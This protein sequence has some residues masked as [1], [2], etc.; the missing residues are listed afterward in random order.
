MRGKLIAVEGID[1][2]GKSVQAALL[3][4]AIER[5]GYTV[6]IIKA[7]ETNQDAAIKKFLKDFDIATDS[8]A[9]MFLYQALHRK[10]YE[11]TKTALD[12][13]NIVI[14]DRWNTS[15]FVY[16]NIFGSLSRQPKHLLKMLNKLAFE[17]LEPDLFCFIAAPVSVAIKRRLIRGDKISS[18]T[19]ESEF[20]EKIAI[21]YKRL[22]TQK[23]QCIVL[24]GSQSIEQVHS[25]I[26]KAIMPVLSK[27]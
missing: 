4:I 14:A 6:Q 24:D 15:F 26:I 18:I 16:H 17:D 5:L 10:Q 8:L 1:G 22:L 11:K 2:S 20:Y 3:K 27:G 21:E 12:A 25:Q 13:G 7:K 19:K 9:F 23:P